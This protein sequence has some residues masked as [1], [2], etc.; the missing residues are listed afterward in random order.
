MAEN[1]KLVYA[2]IGI[3]VGIPLGLT[4]GILLYRVLF[5]EPVYGANYAYDPQT[6]QLIQYMP[7]PIPTTKS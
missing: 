2:L 5:K 6:K 4:L 3:C 1:D 7:I